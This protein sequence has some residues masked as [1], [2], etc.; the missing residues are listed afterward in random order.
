MRTRLNNVQIQT[1]PFKTCYITTCATLQPL[2]PHSRK[3]IYSCVKDVELQ[4]A[5]WFHWGQQ[6]QGQLRPQLCLIR[7]SL[8]LCFCFSSTTVH[9]V[10]IDPPFTYWS[11]LK[12][13]TNGKVD[14]NIPFKSF[15]QRSMMSSK[16]RG[17]SLVLNLL[18][19]DT[20]N[21][22]REREREVHSFYWHQNEEIK[23][24]QK[25]MEKFVPYIQMFR[26]VSWIGLHMCEPNSK[27]AAPKNLTWS[28]W[29]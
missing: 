16:L 6:E 12:V 3:K 27:Q 1:F 23:S 28:V 10:V 21:G 11:C 15:K 24:K 20:K 2:P 18:D 4:Q 19:I 25:V 22:R 13:M 17:T 14:N 9:K 7:L 29:F 26:P 5:Y 8:L